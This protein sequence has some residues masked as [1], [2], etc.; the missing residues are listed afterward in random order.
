MPILGTLSPIAEDV[1]RLTDAECGRLLSL[2]AVRGYRLCP[3]RNGQYYIG[4]I[5]PQRSTWQGAHPSPTA[6]PERYATKKEARRA[7][8][9]LM[10]TQTRRVAA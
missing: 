10:L 4:K 7:L 2:A 1:D 8:L 5:E 3:N 9:R 6:F